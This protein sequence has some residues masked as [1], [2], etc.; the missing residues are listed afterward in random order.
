MVGDDFDL[1]SGPQRA[2]TPRAGTDTAR[3]DRRE[4][5]SCPA[6]PSLSSCSDTL[7]V[8]TSRVFSMHTARPFARLKTRLGAG[9][10][11]MAV[12]VYD[13]VPGTRNER[14]GCAPFKATAVD[15]IKGMSDD[16]LE[17]DPYEDGAEPTVSGLDVDLWS[18][19]TS[20]GPAS[21]TP[22]RAT[23]TR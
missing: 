14:A 22:S 5:R 18:T 9:A 23:A 10:D 8:V 16:G 11:Q 20:R 15:A 13:S 1:F 7:P 2:S 17:P 19:T 3:E 4:L 21:A 12:Q 6:L